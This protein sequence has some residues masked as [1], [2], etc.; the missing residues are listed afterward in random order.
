MLFSH[1]HCFSMCAVEQWNCVGITQ[2]WE[3]HKTYLG[4]SC[5]NLCHCAPTSNACRIWCFLRV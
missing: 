2:N 4:S 5:R 3:H 1:F